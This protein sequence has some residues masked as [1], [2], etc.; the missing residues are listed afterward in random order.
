MLNELLLVERGARQAGIEMAQRHPDLKDARR[1]P[2]LLVRLD[3][4]GD[5]SEVR[6]VPCEVTPWT[7]RDGQHNSFPFV[8]P[9]RPLWKITPSD[10]RRTQL[11]DRKFKSK[12]EVL[13]QLSD[14]AEF[15]SDELMDWPGRGLIERVRE[16]R[17]QL[18]GKGEASIDVVLKTLER[19]VIACV[20]GRS[21]AGLLQQIG[22]HL[23]RNL[24]MTA[25]ADWFELGIAILVE[26]AGGF[27][28]DAAGEN[29]V[30]D[31]EVAA[32]VSAALRTLTDVGPGGS[33]AAGA[34][35]ALTGVRGE[36]V[37]SKFPQPNLPLLG[38]TYLFSRNKDIPAN[39]RYGRFSADSMPVGQDTAI[40]LAAAI[41]AVTSENRKGVT[42]RGIPG[43]S[44]NQTDL[45][46]AFVE[47]AP[48]AAV[49]EMFAEHEDEGG[50][51]TEEDRATRGN[52]VSSFEQR[53][54]RLIEAVRAKAAPL[55]KT[56]VRYAVIRKLDP[57]NRK[58]CYQGQV[59]VADLA[60]AAEEWAAG[61]RNAPLVRLP[62]P[63]VPS[64]K[65]E[66]VAAPHMAPLG[67]IRF[68]KQ[69]F[70]HGGLDRQEITGL[71]ASEVLSLF[72][73]RDRG[74]TTRV[75]RLVLA[76]RSSLV[77]GTAH[78][79]RKGLDAARQFDCREALK[80]VTV[81]GL[82]LYMLGR[83]RGTAEDYMSDEAFKFGQ[84][85]AAVDLVHV[86][87]CADVRSG[88]VPPALLGNQVFAMAQTSPVKALNA[89][90]RRWK[91]Y[92]GWAMKSARAFDAKANRRRDE[93]MRASKNREES[94]RGW[95]ITRALAVS[96]R[97]Q[98][99]MEELRAVLAAA[100]TDV[101]RAEL[102][103]G[104]IAGIPK[105]NAGAPQDEGQAA[106]AATMEE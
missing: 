35:C 78:A 33:N 21:P 13:L 106:D 59:A 103:L 54:Q 24:R 75:L 6:P 31:R 49:V 80:T 2:T 88:Q 98:P 67:L 50:G 14:G 4:N 56:P 65:I 73:D 22:K 83:R 101:F 28:F 17:A 1:I 53:T 46:I 27:M 26:G 74:S 10:Q 92:A 61:E 43:E 76:R 81:L 32:S 95:D 89:L 91:P 52:T 77:V 39:D 84:L 20:D 9:K 30:L 102:L 105:A 90:A 63:A 87:Y 68:S 66:S 64:R 93:L 69:V 47:V 40:R 100:P 37:E 15:N 94:Q 86:G 41:E 42:W 12:H 5:V 23:V 29:S 7:L 44:P 45:L 60:R 70:V 19:F 8:Q 38:Q 18:F 36:M 96:W 79:V 25:A 82:L 55:D 58:I 51:L 85:L 72:L 71:P 3:G 62:V 99:L 48:D 104:Y 57:A 34:C 11:L 16:R 97:V